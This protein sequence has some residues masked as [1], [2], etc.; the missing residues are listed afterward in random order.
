MRADAKGMRGRG[1]LPIAFRT[2]TALAVIT[3]GENVLAGVVVGLLIFWVLP[4]GAEVTERHV[5]GLN[6]SAAAIF[7]GVSIPVGIFWARRW[8]S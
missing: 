6:A 2:K 3:I 7:I 5:L 4:G 8:T 1:Q